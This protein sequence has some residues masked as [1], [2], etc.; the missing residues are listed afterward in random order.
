MKRS[1]LHA[2]RRPARVRS[3]R[4]GG[5]ID[6]F[7]HKELDKSSDF[8]PLF[9]YHRTG[10]GT[11]DKRVSVLVLFL[12]LFVLAVAAV[13]SYVFVQMGRPAVSV[14]PHAYLEIG[15]SGEIRE[16][17]PPDLFRDVVL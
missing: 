16:I 9:C 15:L 11:M 14:P 4:P 3:G 12:I 8:S 13:V 17:A 5:G 2:R 6:S 1:L 7:N 10:G